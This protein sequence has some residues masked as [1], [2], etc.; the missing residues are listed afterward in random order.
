MEPEG[1]VTYE[2]NDRI[3]FVTK[4]HDVSGATDVCVSERVALEFTCLDR[5][6]FKKAAYSRNIQFPLL[7]N[8][9]IS[10]SLKD[11][12]SRAGA[13][14][15]SQSSL[16]V[17]H[18]IQEIG[19]VDW[20]ASVSPNASYDTVISLLN[21]FPRNDEGIVFSFLSDVEAD[22]HYGFHA[23][24]PNGNI[25]KG[26]AA[27]V[28]ISSAHK[29]NMP[30]SIS[31]GFQI[32]T[33]DVKD[34]PNLDAKGS[35]TSYSFTGYCSLSDVSK[36]V[37]DPLRR[38]G[39]RSALGFINRCEESTKDDSGIRHK[40]FQLNKAELLDAAGGKDAVAAFQRLRRLGMRI[41]P[42]NKDKRTRNLILRRNLRALSRNA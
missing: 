19:V 24:F 34:A 17:N 31:D 8:V 14:Q 42:Q 3:W 1:S 28:L 25:V 21:N 13:S 26:K 30:V 38:Q 36:F 18:T 40:S 35:Q 20:T 4:L 27:V 37:M 10:R 23:G 9:C 2:G 15:P 29:S 7:C 5:E 33:E 32:T 11:A 12:P 16:Y 6:G 39:P 22:P 41:N